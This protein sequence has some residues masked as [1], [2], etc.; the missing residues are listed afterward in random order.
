MT[1]KRE[2]LPEQARESGDEVGA[3]LGFGFPTLHHQHA[4]VAIGS[5]CGKRYR[6]IEPDFRLGFGQLLDI[7]RPD[8]AAANDDEVLSDGR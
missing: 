7:L 2:F 3:A 4:S 6:T 1:F 5:G 8:V